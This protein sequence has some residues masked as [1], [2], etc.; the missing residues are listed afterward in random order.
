[1][2]FVPVDGGDVVD[3]FDSNLGFLRSLPVLLTTAL[4]RFE[5]LASASKYITRT[6]GSGAKV[7]VKQ[8]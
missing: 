2:S 6:A 3:Q 1:M 5:T 4:G 8:C 7:A